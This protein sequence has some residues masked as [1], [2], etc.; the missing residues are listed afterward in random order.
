MVPLQAAVSNVIWY[1]DDEQCEGRFRAESIP[2][3]CFTRLNICIRE[4]MSH[5][6]LYI[7]ITSNVVVL[8]QEEFDCGTSS[9]HCCTFWIHFQFLQGSFSTALEWGLPRR[10]RAIKFHRYR[11]HIRRRR[12]RQPK[13]LCNCAPRECGLEG[14]RA[15][16]SREWEDWDKYRGCRIQHSSYP[17]L[18]HLV[19]RKWSPVALISNTSITGTDWRISNIKL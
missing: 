18:K 19:L 11:H 3:N 12:R 16:Q 4:W 15:R 14:G 8:S 2:K 6:A 9:S 7:L 17:N 5:W 10:K 1:D 13:R